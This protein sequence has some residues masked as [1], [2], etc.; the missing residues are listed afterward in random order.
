MISKRIAKERSPNKG[1]SGR[2]IAAD[3]QE[4]KMFKKVDL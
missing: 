3:A 4:S 1:Y 2:R